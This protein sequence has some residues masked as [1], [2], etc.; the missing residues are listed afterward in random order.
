MG[1]GGDSLGLITLTPLPEGRGEY[2]IWIGTCKVE[3]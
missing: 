2:C 1:L 3:M